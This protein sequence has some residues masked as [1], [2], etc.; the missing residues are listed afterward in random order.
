VGAAATVPPEVGAGAA[1]AGVT[2]AAVGAGV[3]G[4]VVLVVVA[5]AGAAVVVV[6]GGVI[7]VVTVVA[8]GVMSEPGTT[9]WLA[10]SAFAASLGGRIRRAAS[11]ASSGP[12]RTRT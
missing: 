1:C 5:A 2:G 12:G 10:I 4:G 11:A 9:P 7:V 3:T 6:A 8:A